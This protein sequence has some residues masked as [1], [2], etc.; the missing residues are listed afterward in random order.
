MDV[1]WIHL[2]EDQHAS[3]KTVVAGK[4]VDLILLQSLAQWLIG[5]VGIPKKCIMWPNVMVNNFSITIEFNIVYFVFKH[6]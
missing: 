5:G 6:F 2:M 1:Q 4:Y 3:V